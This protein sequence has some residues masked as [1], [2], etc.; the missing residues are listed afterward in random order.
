MKGRNKGG[1]VE[2]CSTFEVSAMSSDRLLERLGSEQFATAACTQ[3]DLKGLWR[4]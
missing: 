4:K 1:K 3:P 2:E